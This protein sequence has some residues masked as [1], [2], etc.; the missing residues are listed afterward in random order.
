MALFFWFKTGIEIDSFVLGNYKIDKLYIKL[1]KKLTLKA[2]KV[3]IPKSKEKPSFKNID[4]TFDRIKYFFTFFHT[5]DLKEVV[6][7]DNKVQFMFT[8]NLF[9]LSS[10]RYEI[11]GNIYRNAEIFTADVP[12]LYLK[13]NNIT[14]NGE[15]RYS[16]KNNTLETKGDFDAYHIQGHFNANK[17][18]D[19]IRFRLNSDRFNDIKTLVNAV[20]LPKS[21][22]SWLVDKIKA[23]EYQINTLEGSGSI[24]DKGFKLN[25]KT[26]KATMLLRKAKIYFQPKLNPIL[27]KEME[28][29]YKNK[30]LFFTFK[31]PTYLHKV[32]KPSKVM[33]TG[34]GS[35]KTLLYL[36]LFMQTAIDKTL[37]QILDAYKVKF[38]PLKYKGAPVGIGL[39]MGI[40]LG[41]WKKTKKMLTIVNVAFEQGQ[42]QIK[43]ISL[44]LLKATIKYDNRAKEKVSISST[45]KK[46]VLSIGET[47]IPVL[48]GQLSYKKEQ[49]ILEKVYTKGLWY[50]GMVNGKI[51]LKN[52]KAFLNMEAK[53]IAIGDKEKFIVIENKPMPLM[54]DY[55]KNFRLSMPTLGM[56]LINKEDGMHIGVTDITKLKPYLKHMP[57]AID[58]GSI[59][60]VKKGDKYS[61]KGLLRSK[62]CFFYDKN[63]VC[64]TQIRCLGEVSKKGLDF[65]AFDKRLHYRSAKSRLT[66]KNLNIDLKKFLNIRKKSKKN[67]STKLIILGNN[68]KIRY[69]KHI[70]LTDS[71]DIEILPNGN[72]KASGSLDGDIVQFNKKGNIVSMKALRVKDKMLHALINFDGLQKGRYTLKKS[73]NP[74]KVLKGQIII[75]GGV[76]SNFKAYN[77]TLALINAVPAL[78]TFSSPGFSKSGFMI[79]EGVIEYRMTKD[80]IIFDSIYI[81]GSSA[82]IVGKGVLSLKKKNMHMKL[83]IQTARELGNLVGKVPLLGYIL[84][85]KDKSI[86]VGLTIEGSIYKPVVRTS[87]AQDILTLPLQFIQRTIESTVKIIK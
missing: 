62:A 25:D 53:K 55:A 7:A 54:I 46:G 3:V 42:M 79:K 33:I 17:K 47:K 6:F 21:I 68:S 43:N 60:I 31:T 37:Q 44:P 69:E 12:R 16:L 41:K 38:P 20:S 45:L 9:Y 64:R 14:L 1:D 75:E 65:Y 84:M 59:D 76:M 35:K 40:P 5:I 26:L 87:T 66:L 52:K 58:G 50:E 51:D 39:K 28:I 32:L 78:A 74:D 19:K 4:S 77:N 63:D 73:G 11:A 29:N 57:I 10:D 2:N 34:I 72:V 71:Y 8:D 80:K 22:Q 83:A 48:N 67:K 24:V 27:A 86:T 70:L 36:D 85:G 18:E 82:T 30:S 23:K 15:L 49:V 81:K 13:E 56:K 61:F